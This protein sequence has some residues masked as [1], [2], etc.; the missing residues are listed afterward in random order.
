VLGPDAVVVAH[1]NGQARPRLRSAA[2]LTGGAFAVASAVAAAGGTI[3]LPGG[4]FV[5]VFLHAL[6]PPR[7]VVVAADGVAVLDRSLFRRRPT[8]VVAALTHRDLCG[9]TRHL[10]PR[11]A[12]VPLGHDWVTLPTRELERLRRAATQQLRNAA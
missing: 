4:L 12:S 9:Y 5:L 7:L 6:M 3:L 11:K 1:S 2:V 10:S 8:K